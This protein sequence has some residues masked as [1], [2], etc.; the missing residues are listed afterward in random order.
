MVIRTIKTRF[1]RQFEG[2]QIHSFSKINL[3][4]GK[5]GQ[6][7]SN[8]GLFA[9]LF[10]LQGYTGNQTLSE[11]PTRGKS[12]ESSVEI[13][14]Y[15]KGKNYTITRSYP[16]DIKI[17]CDGVEVVLANNN[18]KQ[19]YLNKLFGN[20]EYFRKFRMVDNTF[21]NKGSNFLEEGKVSLNKILLSLNQEAFNNI[22]KRLNEKK[23]ERDKYNID[24]I[25]VSKHFPSQK[26]LNI[27]DSSLL[28]WKERLDILDNEL[29]NIN[30]NVIQLERNKAQ[31]ESMSSYYQSQC[32]KLEVQQCPTC[33]QTIS[34]EYRKAL[35]GEMK[36]KIN[37]LI[38]LIKEF[39]VDI[40]NE[41]EV[42]D[43]IWKEKNEVVKRRDKLYNLRVVLENRIKQ[44]DFIYTDRDI[45]VI[46]KAIEELD[47]F[48]SF[49]ITEWV[50]VLEPIINSVISKIGHSIE[51]KLDE[52]GQF[53]IKLYKDGQEWEYQDLSN[54]QK[55]VL[56]IA[57]KM[58]LLLEQNDD[59]VIVADEGFGSLDIDNLDHIFE[60]FNTMPF[61]LICVLHRY[62]D[63]TNKM[64]VINL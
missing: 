19:D 30:N 22:R 2:E 46:K 9:I 6:G 20:V 47:K 40:S 31:K 34:E 44:K 4:K 38:G 36:Q 12:K 1:F 50:K 24:R 57:F 7:K 48:Y 62:E 35:Q 21:G 8:L 45:L 39:N 56:S 32:V 52:K 5:N 54:G 16:T 17:I 3:I 26:R 37:E 51:F 28:Q 53:D 59:G 49:Y 64:N 29:R 55:T 42:N 41:K 11:I 23:S 43:Q 15:H 14:L 33:K 27:L 63:T 13:E 61:Q 18:L 58:A 10:C 60:L 25:V